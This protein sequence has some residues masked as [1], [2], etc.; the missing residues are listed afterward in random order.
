MTV[1][2]ACVKEKRMAADRWC[3]DGDEHFPMRKVYR[4]KGLLIG[5]AGDIPAINRAVEWMRK[6]S[7]PDNVPGGDV[8]ALILSPRGL[9]TWTPTDGEV[10]VP[11]PFAVGSGSACARAA[12]KAGAD[13]KRA[14]QITN[15]VHSQCGGGV[16]VYKL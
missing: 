9:T 11:S 4:I 5:F 13:V 2:A 6:G 8:V 15:D 7:S 10:S 3:L 1:I 12:M 14:V 16:S